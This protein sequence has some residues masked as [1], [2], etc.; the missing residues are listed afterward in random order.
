MRKRKLKII[1]VL[2][3]ALLYAFMISAYAYSLNNGSVHGL[4]EKLVVLDDEGNSVSENGSYYFSV[5]DMKPKITYTKNI[6]IMNL[7]DDK[8]YNIYF[9]AESVSSKGEIDLENECECVIMLDGE[10]V[11]RGKVSGKGNP[12]MQKA[13]LDLGEYAPNEYRHMQVN[14]TWD[15]TSAGNFID[16][17]E[18]VVTASGTEITRNKSGETFISGETEFKWIFTA[19]VKEEDTSSTS[20]AESSSQAASSETS[21]K[22]VTS[23]EVS[24]LVASTTSKNTS[25]NSSVS[26]ST[27]SKGNSSQESSSQESSSQESEPSSSSEAFS[28]VSSLSD[29]TI[30][31]PTQSTVSTVLSSTNSKATSTSESSKVS[32]AVTIESFVQTGEVVAIFAIT[33]IMLASLVLIVLTA[34]RK[35]REE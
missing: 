27:S 1:A 9:G 6:Q 22:E 10:E 30:S 35:Q 25:S 33:S 18:R 13:P 24:S 17:G 2:T 4:P 34:V 32:S 19:E 28:G 16:N 3:A 7:R 12:D 23:S 29:G 15:G 14:V 11:Y 31:K 26:S 5:T 21:S 8:S 20:S